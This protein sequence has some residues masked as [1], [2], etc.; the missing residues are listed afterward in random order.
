MIQQL[1]DFPVGALVQF[2]WN[3]NGQDGASI[4]R[5]TNGTIRIW[6]NNS[7]TQRSS[8]NGI[9]DTEDFD[10]QTGIHYCSID[11]S[12]NTDAGFYAAGNEYFVA[13]V[14]AVIDTLTVNAVLAQF[15]IAN[16]T[17]RANV[18]QV[19]GSAINNLIS[20]RVDANAQAVGDK[21]GYTASTVSD[22][23]GYAL[24][25]TGLNSVVTAEP[26]SIPAF[27]NTIVSAIS[28]I[29]AFCRNKITQTSSAQT[30]RND[31]DSGTI[32]TSTHSD[33]GTTHVRGKFT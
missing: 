18:V 8:A 23:T 17:P 25:A 26:A 31:A 2:M 16:R 12:D 33:D 1:G 32:G 6:K 21:T 7:V 24:S 22:K 29:M 14:G 11:L 15:S 28:L 5:A 19:N 20:G 4:T 3:T 9:T 10:A 27:G 30:L 13:I